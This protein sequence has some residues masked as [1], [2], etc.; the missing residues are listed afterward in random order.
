[1]LRLS[2]FKSVGGSVTFI[3]NP[4][5]EGNDASIYALLL[6]YA[7]YIGRQMDLREDKPIC[8]DA[9]SHLELRL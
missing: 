7:E 2:D 6:L 8:L 5:D 9:E 3:A 1:M 4:G